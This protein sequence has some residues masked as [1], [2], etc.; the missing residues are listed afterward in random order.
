MSQKSA[1]LLYEYMWK[2]RL[3]Q[4]K[5]ADKFLVSRTSIYKYLLGKPIH[6]QVAKKIERATHGLI[7]AEDLK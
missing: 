4:E 3:T 2:N 1:D 6:P 5:M 7:K